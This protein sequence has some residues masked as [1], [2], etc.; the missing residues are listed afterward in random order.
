ML[1]KLRH[2]T[3]FKNLFHGFFTAISLAQARLQ[4][5]VERRVVR[6]PRTCL[7]QRV[8]N[9][10]EK[11]QDH[12]V[13]RLDQILKFSEHIR[14]AMGSELEKLNENFRNFTKK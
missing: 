10:S 12:I 9:F 13:S 11:S 14:L 5:K 7:V 8:V 3:F 6:Q 4:L 2:E 1:E